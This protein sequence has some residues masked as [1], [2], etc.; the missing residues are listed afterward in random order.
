MDEADFRCDERTSVIGAKR[1]VGRLARIAVEAAGQIN[2]QS[3][4]VGG[5][6]LADHDIKGPA[7]RAHRPG[8][9]NCVNDPFR[10]LELALQRTS[11]ELA[12]H[13]NHRQTTSAD[14]RI[15]RGGIA[16]KFV[17]WSNEYHLHWPPAQIEMPRNDKTI[18]CVIAFAANNGHGS[19][20]AE[21]AKDINAAS[22]RV[23]HEHEPRHSKFVNRAAIDI[24]DFRSA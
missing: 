12:R 14:N 19:A 23:L 13:V 15:I 2:G 6:H 18:P 21:L 3:F 4:A 7:W 24:A 22:A 5:I 9:K 11:T 8:S 16:P 1:G 10:V 17:R 20:A